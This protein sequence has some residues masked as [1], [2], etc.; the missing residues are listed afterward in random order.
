MKEPGKHLT[1]WAIT[2]TSGAVRYVKTE[3]SA[4]SEALSNPYV[5]GIRAPV[6]L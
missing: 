6:Y 2:Y 4:K 5:I 1:H 3:E